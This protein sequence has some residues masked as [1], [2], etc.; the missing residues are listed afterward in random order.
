M[1][2][3]IILYVALMAFGL[4]VMPNTVSL[5]AGQHTFYSGMGVQCEK[6]HSDILPQL[7]AGGSYGK[8]LAAA[9][10]TNYTTY[11]ALG[12][13]LY[14]NGKIT[15]YNGKIWT[16]NGAGWQNGSD[17]QNVNLDKD[18]MNGIDGDEICMLCHNATLTG[19]IE[20]TG[21]VI[22]ACDDDRCHGNR[23]NISNSP[24]LLG[25]TPNI[26]AAGYNLSQ[27]NIHQPF[28]LGA[29]NQSSRYVAAI[30]FG[31]P[32]NAYGS[33]ISR[34]YWACEGCHTETTINITINQAP[35]FNH[36]VSNPN[37]RRY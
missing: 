19:S 18:K 12:G 17:I 2:K 4:Y 27:V 32:G 6:C 21:L 33:F 1:K 26:T 3:I 35:V 36:S 8:H 9:G 37:K 14:S 31:Q 13:V 10:N 11:L 16:W 28:Y 20:H 30:G 34:G 5:F 24:E 22:R 25:S 15:A 29:S 7:V 23:N